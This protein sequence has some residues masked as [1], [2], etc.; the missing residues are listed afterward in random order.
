MPRD[1]ALWMQLPAGHL[2]GVSTVGTEQ[3]Y[4]CREMEQQIKEHKKLSS[5]AGCQCHQPGTAQLFLHDYL[6]S[7]AKQ[8]QMR[9]ILV[10]GALCSA[11]V[12]FH[13]GAHH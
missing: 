13:Y 1:H 9:L 4:S 3:L 5:K 6:C 7:S 8:L 12:I 11:F 10:I 2:G